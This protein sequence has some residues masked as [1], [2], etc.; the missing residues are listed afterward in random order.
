MLKK[1]IIGIVAIPALAIGLGPA[2]GSGASISPSSQT[3]GSGGSAS[4]HLSAFGSGTT[5]AKLAY[6]DGSSTQW[7]GVSGTSANPWTKNVSHLFL[8]NGTTYGQTFTAWT[9]SASAITHAPIGC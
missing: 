2:F 7:T 4:W 6:G 3:V 5:T 1:A 8:C 9:A